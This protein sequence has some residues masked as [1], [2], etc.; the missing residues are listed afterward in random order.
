[1]VAALVYGLAAFVAAI[2]VATVCTLVGGSEDGFAGV[3]ARTF[4]IFLA[5]QLLTV[6]QGLAYGLVFLNTPAAI[7]TYF[8]L[9]IASQIVFTLVPAL[10]D[11]APWLDL[12]T[13]QQPLFSGAFELTGE[14]Y[15]QLGTTTVLWILV[16]F[17]VGLARV[18][19]TELK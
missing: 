10:R 13:A 14:Q 4:L 8:V 17:L 11:P 3:A 15:A 19:R 6:L 5:L 1:V 18:L 2:L 16:P 9:P 7:V 12:G